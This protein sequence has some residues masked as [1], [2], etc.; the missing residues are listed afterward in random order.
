[1]IQGNGYN[2]QVINN[3]LE[4]KINIQIRKNCFKNGKNPLL[5]QLIRKATKWTAIIIE[6][7][8]ACLLHI[9]FSQIYC[10]QE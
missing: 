6:E 4:K 7:F 9:K 1:M 8:H 3:L 5:F 10:Y 2:L